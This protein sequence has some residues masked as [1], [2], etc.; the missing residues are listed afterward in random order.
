MQWNLP[1]RTKTQKKKEMMNRVRSQKGPAFVWMT[2]AG[3]FYA[4][5]GFYGFSHAFSSR[6]T[7]FL[8]SSSLRLAYPSTTVWLSPA[9]SW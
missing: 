5:K 9:D 7:P 1:S 2:E 8:I 6:E 3:P 4:M